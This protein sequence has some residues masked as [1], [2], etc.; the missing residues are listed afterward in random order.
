MLVAPWWGRLLRN[1]LAD[2]IRT[3]AFTE[4]TD[5]RSTGENAL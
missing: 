3:A 2:T 5:L 1:F 4:I